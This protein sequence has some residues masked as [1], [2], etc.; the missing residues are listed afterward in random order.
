VTD[1]ERVTLA[2]LYA[3]DQTLW[4]MPLTHF[5]PIDGNYPVGNAGPS[6]GESPGTSE[7]E[8]E[9][10][11]H[12][13]CRGG[14][15]IECQNQVL[16][17]EI[18][19]TGTPFSLNYRS[20]RVAGFRATRVIDVGV[21]GASVS[22]SL[23]GAEVRVQVAGRDTMVRFDP[24]PGQRFHYEWDGRDAYGRPKRY[25]NRDLRWCTRIPACIGSPKTRAAH[26]VVS[27]E[28]LRVLG[29]ALN[30]PSEL[31]RG[32]RRTI[33]SRVQL[34]PSVAWNAVPQGMGGWSL[35]VHH[36]YDPSGRMIYYGDGRR[37]EARDIRTP[38]VVAGNGTES[39]DGNDGPATN[40]GFVTIADVIAAPDGGFFVSDR[41][42][43]TV[44]RV[45]PD[46]VIEAVAGMT[47]SPGFSGDNGP[48]DS[49]Q[50]NGPAG[51]ALGPDG[52]VYIADANNF[53]VRRVTPS[54]SI[55][56]V[57]GTDSTGFG[58]DGGPATSAV[59][60]APAAVTVAPDGS[61]YIADNGDTSRV[62][63]VSTDGRIVTVAGG[64]TDPDLCQ[65]DSILAAQ[66]C[67]SGQL[68]DITWG[69]DD[70]LYVLQRKQ[71]LRIGSDGLATRIAGAP[72]S[73]CTIAPGHGGAARDAGLCATSVA[74]AATGEVYLADNDE[75]VRVIERDG[76]IERI[77]SGRCGYDGPIIITHRDQTPILLASNAW[78]LPSSMVESGGGCL[79][80][81]ALAP[82]G[83]LLVTDPDSGL[84]NRLQPDLPG[85]SSTNVVVAA[86]DGSELYVF[87]ADGRHLET[88]KALNGATLLAFAYDTVGRLVTITDADS[89]V[90]T[91]ERDGSG[92][93]TGILGP[94]GQPTTLTVDSNAYLASVTNPAGEVIHLTHD[95]KGLLARIVNPLGD[96]TA[97]T[98]D[99]LGR[100]LREDDPAGG[101]QALARDSGV[102]FTTAEGRVT[103]YEVE[104]TGTEQR[105]RTVLP[106]GLAVTTTVAPNAGKGLVMTT[107]QTPDGMITTMTTRRDPRFSAAEV[108]DSIEV[109][110]PSSLNS[111]TRAWR[112][113]ALADPD[114]P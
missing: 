3:A 106:T 92:E 100:F 99:S 5:T 82:D 94:F 4:R 50:L 35:D 22:P 30:V 21:L 88:R 25:R 89:N 102:T 51:L 58:G 60:S 67:F 11:D 93:V 34:G 95:A 33:V 15:V 54:G 36:A 42:D 20:D 85:V 29:C 105:R 19:V 75:R 7:S 16:G 109:I 104:Q 91:I 96:T 79:N 45:R 8:G 77:G 38:R 59:L 80:A 18:D 49:A 86:P 84:V 113:V 26:S 90:T 69:P 107:T 28:L 27:R 46:G 62:R 10:V 78:V 103:R 65:T 57:A 23:L 87:S 97:F 31:Q 98:Y 72:D 9:H 24:T 66:T 12:P 81:V 112:T 110:A 17:E 32:V 1:A 40:A 114:D 53:R 63:K 101:F 48:A 14:S 70:A 37:V 71:L 52:S 43:H 47:G 41:G 2:G 64:G 61:L 111:Q 39:P 76:T 6:G 83:S 73:S 44:R 68:A 56:T 108:M 55:E 74:V 13:D